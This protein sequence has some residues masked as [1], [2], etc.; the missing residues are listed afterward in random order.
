VRQGCGAIHAASSNRDCTDK[1]E[2]ELPQQ[3]T[4]T[5]RDDG[6]LDGRVA[7]RDD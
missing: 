1:D 6:L 5:T 2:H 4:R 7:E 3:L